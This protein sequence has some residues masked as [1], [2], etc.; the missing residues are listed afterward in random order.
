MGLLD[1]NL[2][3]K[4]DPSMGVIVG[5]FKILYDSFHGRDAG[6]KH[7]DVKGLPFAPL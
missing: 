6:G 7:L 4:N 2:Y 5:K 1:A 3:L